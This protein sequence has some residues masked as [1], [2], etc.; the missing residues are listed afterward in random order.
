MTFINSIILLAALGCGVFVPMVVGHFLAIHEPGKT[1]YALG[2]A[3]ASAILMMLH[4]KLAARTV[5]GAQHP[6]H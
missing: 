6:H 3:A 2:F 5:T 1:L 4:N